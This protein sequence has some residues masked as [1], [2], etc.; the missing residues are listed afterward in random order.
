MAFDALKS[1]G[2][3]V[4]KLICGRTFWSTVFRPIGVYWL[5]T[6]AMTPIVLMTA[7]SEEIAILRSYSILFWL[8]YGVWATLGLS[9]FTWG[10]SYWRFD[11]RP[12][13][14]GSFA[15]YPLVTGAITGPILWVLF[16]LS[17]ISE[18]M[19]VGEKTAM[20]IF[21][22]IAGPVQALIA[23]AATRYILQFTIPRK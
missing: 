14:A 8:T 16:S 2:H 21:G 9:W 4:I 22:L 5:L 18:P 6:L 13:K 23:A 17:P 10:L 3:S 19:G 1:L 20:T 7:P 11:E 12:V 15:L